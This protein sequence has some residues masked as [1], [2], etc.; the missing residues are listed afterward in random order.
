[1]KKFLSFGK[2]L[3]AALDGFRVTFKDWDTTYKDPDTGEIAKC[4]TYL[5]EEES[6]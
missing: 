6:V 1:M 4:P 2:A 3:E 5:C